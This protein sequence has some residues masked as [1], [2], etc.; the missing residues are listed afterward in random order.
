MKQKKR[1]PEQGMDFLPGVLEAIR[2]FRDAGYL[3]AVAFSSPVDVEEV[4]DVLG[5]HECFTS[6]TSVETR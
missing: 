3:S 5:I 6:I 2:K 1:D 4:L